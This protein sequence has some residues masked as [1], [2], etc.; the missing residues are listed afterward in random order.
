MKDINQDPMSLDKLAAVIKVGFGDVHAEISN[1]HTELNEKAE[2]VD[3]TLRVEVGALK[4]EVRDG[5]IG[6][7]HRLADIGDKLGDH[8]KRI[9]GIEHE[10]AP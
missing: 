6:V 4:K 3:A 2:A 8:E 7:N 5:F 10:L 9:T 1:A